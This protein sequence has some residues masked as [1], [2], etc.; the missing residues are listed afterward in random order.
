VVIGGWRTEN[1]RFR[2]L[3]AGQMDD[4]KLRYVGRIHTGYS[5]AKVGELLPRLQDR[6]IA[7]SPFQLGDVPTLRG[8]H[9]VRPELVARVTYAE[10]TSAGKLRQ[11]A[12][13]GLREKAPEH[14]TAEAPEPPPEP[15]RRPLHGVALRSAPRSTI[16]TRCSGPPRAGRR[17]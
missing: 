9:W 12:Y 3:L 17:R 6:E 8:V 11:A 1:G 10:I 2:S 5:A 4:G 15:A 14:V 13:H 16:P 7:K